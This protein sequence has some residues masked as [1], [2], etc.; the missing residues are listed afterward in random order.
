MKQT[1]KKGLEEALDKFKLSWLSI[2]G[3]K[4]TIG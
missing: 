2:L 3:D 4:H 1:V